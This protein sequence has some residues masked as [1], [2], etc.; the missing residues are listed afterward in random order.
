[1]R[2][3][4]IQHMVGKLSQHRDFK[5]ALHSGPSVQLI[6]LSRSE[7]AEKLVQLFGPKWDLQELC[8]TVRQAQLG[9]LGPRVSPSAGR[10]WCK[11][12]CRLANRACWR[13]APRTPDEQ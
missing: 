1:M 2:C 6:G 5:W 10:I 8:T 12:L 7:V 4:I 3:Q 13:P 11:G 9:R